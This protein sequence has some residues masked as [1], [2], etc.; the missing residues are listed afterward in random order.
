ML[1]RR[2]NSHAFTRETLGTPYG[3]N[4]QRRPFPG[5]GRPLPR[6]PMPIGIEQVLLQDA[7]SRG[8]LFAERKPEWETAHPS[9]RR[10]RCSNAKRGP[11]RSELMTPAAAVPCNVV[12][13]GVKCASGSNFSP[14]STRVDARCSTQSQRRP[15][16]HGSN[17]LIAPAVLL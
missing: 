12:R 3:Q 16:W 2:G 14:S 11:G 17:S 13:N 7:T 15:W 1:P 9:P 4:Q 5:L 6:C 8:R 10:M